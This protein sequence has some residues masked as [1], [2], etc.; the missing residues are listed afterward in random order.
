MNKQRTLFADKYILS[1]WA[2][3]PFWH[4]LD[5]QGRALMNELYIGL[6]HKGYGSTAGRLLSLQKADFVSDGYHVNVHSV[7]L[8]Y[9]V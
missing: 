9:F 7:P 5:T 1:L 4:L 8:P 6:L 3:V 2:N